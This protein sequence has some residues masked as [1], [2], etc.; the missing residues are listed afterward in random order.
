MPLLRAK[1][2]SP[3]IHYPGSPAGGYFRFVIS[4]EHTKLQLDNLAHTLV[5]VRIK[6]LKSQTPEDFLSVLF[7]LH[8]GQIFDFAVRSNEKCHA[9]DAE[10]FP[11]VPLPPYAIGFNDFSCPRPQTGKRQFKLPPRTC[12][13]FDWDPRLRPKHH[14]RLS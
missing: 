4:S 9:M 13:A 1:N 10:V 6:R 11:L 14:H 7:R 3:L 12:R 8:L 5:S 2:P